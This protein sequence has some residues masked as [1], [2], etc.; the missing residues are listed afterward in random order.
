M[1]GLPA[2][3]GGDPAIAA[4]FHKTIESFGYYFSFQG[5]VIPS[6]TP[7][8]RDQMTGVV[9]SKIKSTKCCRSAAEQKILRHIP[10]GSTSR[11][12]LH[13][14]VEL[15]EPPQMTPLSSEDRV[16]PSP[17]APYADTSQGW[18]SSI[19]TGCSWVLSPHAARMC[20]HPGRYRSRCPSCPS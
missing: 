20:L 4:F 8:I 6:T 10:I 2:C 3:D 18:H 15:G 1:P 19:S 13:G 7:V 9:I 17:A 14:W 12:E 16:I 11:D 5:E